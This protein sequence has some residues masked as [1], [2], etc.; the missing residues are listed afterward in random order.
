MV[1]VADTLYFEL[2][3]VA[4]HDESWAVRES[5]ALSFQ[6]LPMILAEHRYWMNEGRMHMTFLIETKAVAVVAR[7]H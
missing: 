6:R 2:V 1:I 5:A 4:V 7:S 3:F